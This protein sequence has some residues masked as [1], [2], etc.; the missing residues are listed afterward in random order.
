MRFRNATQRR[1]ARFPAETSVPQKPASSIW[2]SAGVPEFAPSIPPRNTPGISKN[3][4]VPGNV[5]RFRSTSRTPAILSA[6]SVPPDWFPVP[7]VALNPKS[8]PSSGTSNTPPP[9]PTMPAAT[10][11][12][13][14]VSK[15][16]TARQKF[17]F[18]KLHPC[19]RSSLRDGWSSATKESPTTS[20]K[21]RKHPLA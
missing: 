13:P 6:E 11:Q 3:S 9:I 8:R 5:A 19:L 15:I 17:S 21:H 4:R 2:D 7:G 20:G 10:P 12:N 1:P 18:G 14:A 16:P